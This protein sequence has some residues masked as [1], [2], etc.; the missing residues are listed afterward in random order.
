MDDETKY[1]F[2]TSAIKQMNTTFSIV[3]ATTE[4]DDSIQRSLDN[5]KHHIEMDL[6]QIDDDFSIEKIAR[7][8]GW[9]M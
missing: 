3:I 2:L 5:A 9:Y 4:P 8:V 1:Y 6:H 7:S